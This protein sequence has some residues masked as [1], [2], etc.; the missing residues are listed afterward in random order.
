MANFADLILGADTRQMDKAVHSL[1][2][3]V[4][5]GARAE[6]ATDGVGKGFDKAGTKA[7]A[8]RP[9]IKGFATD[10]MSVEKVAKMAARSLGVLAAG[11]ISIQ[12]IGSATAEARAFNA[13]ISETSTLI[14]GTPRQLAMLE[15][16]ARSM[17]VQFGTTG[18]QQVEAFYQAISAGAG[19]V[20]QSAE[21]LEQ[22]NKF[23]IGGVTS[24]TIAVDALTTATNSYKASNLTAAQASDAMF[25]GIRAGKTTAAELG[26]ALGNVLPIASALNVS[27][28]EVV[29]TTAALTTQGLTT[30]QSVTGL[31]AALTAVTGP[32]KQASD[33]A[34]QLGIEFNTAAIE[35]MGLKGFL[36]QIVVATG[37]SADAMRA[38]FGS[39]EATTAVLALAGGGS[40]QLT[41]ILEQM[42]NKLGATETAFQKI[43][44]SLDGRLNRATAALGDI[45]LGLGNVIL[46]ILVP[47]AEAMA[48][49]MMLL[50]NNTDA[51]GVAIG[52]LAASKIPALIS[53]MLGSVSLLSIMEVQFIAGA[54][55]ARGMAVAMNLIPGVAIFTGITAALTSTYRAYGE[56]RDRAEEYA[57]SAEVAAKSK[58]LLNEQLGIYIKSHAPQAR[59]LVIK[60]TQAQIEHARSILLVAEANVKMFETH[61]N[62]LNPAL[63][64]TEAMLESQARAEEYKIELEGLRIQLSSL[65]RDT[66]DTAA[67]L[68]DTGSGFSDLSAGAKEATA[69]VYTVIPSLIE[70]R[71]EYGASAEAMRAVL[72][73]QNELAEADASAGFQKVL[74]TVLT[75]NET[76]G[77]GADKVA[78]LKAD[79]EAIGAMDTFGQ[80]SRAIAEMASYI[81][82]AAGGLDNMDANTRGVYQ[83][84]LAAS[85]EA[86][87]LGSQIAIAEASTTTLGAA[88]AR[89]APQFAP[90]IVA[91]N[92]LATAIANIVSQMGG[93]ASGLLRLSTSASAVANVTSAAGGFLSGLSTKVL[94]SASTG[95][96]GV[97]ANLGAV[98]GQSQKSGASVQSLGKHLNSLVNPAGSGG[99]GGGAAKKL[100]EEAKEAARQLK[101]VERAAEQLEQAINRP[102]VSAIDGFANAIGDFVAGGLRDFKKLG[103]AILNTIV[104]SI[105]QAIAFAVANPIKIVLGLSGGLTGGVAQAA[106]GA[107][108]GGGGGGLLGGIGSIG[109]ALAGGFMNSVGSLFSSGVG[110]MFSSIGAQVG[111]AFATGTGTAIAGAIGAIAAP[112]LAVAA[113]FS[114]FRKK[115]TELD[116]GI[117]VTVDGMSTLVETFQTLETKRFWGLSKKVRT[118]YTE[119]DEDVAAP[120]QNIVA[121][122]Q[123]SLISAAETLGITS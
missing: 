117:R 122:I 39:V 113:V 86:G 114:F 115:I 37:G 88:I 109:G 73:A 33:L 26:A 29:A 44:S 22:S 28:D 58:K 79:I 8:A 43:N 77:L 106:T 27:F 66:R 84:L 103:Q 46:P 108:G 18:K 92:R 98:F 15:E 30:A 107:A 25:V 16:S 102:L 3:V 75:L 12:G 121:E 14:E 23:A 57:A 53:G 112:L 36:D 6:K 116:R 20:R 67:G 9:K 48:G 65:L 1:D 61:R 10:A 56:A 120:L 97:A 99:G 60:E 72:M 17:G 2:D 74:A 105:S 7:Q 34:A 71:E 51:L 41:S 55:A 100:S 31:R 70:L 118:T 50:A 42:E 123:D 59:D 119:A 40:A 52:I 80:Q 35:S 83:A 54:V 19:D 13:S 90:A 5:H 93:L 21:L 49:A 85:V 32:T 76:L 45:L 24:T 68:G 95:L 111:T 69:Q 81:F 96:A 82:N 47:A 4:E 104:S 87:A 89:I 78:F 62:G 64:N 91:A 38:L 63:R 110:G 101:E 94:K 11:F